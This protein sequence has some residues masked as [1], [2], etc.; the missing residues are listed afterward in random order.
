MDARRIAVSVRHQQ[1]TD[2][3]FNFSNV[4]NFL[5]QLPKYKSL[6]VTLSSCFWTWETLQAIDQLSG[7]I[8]LRNIQITYLSN[9]AEVLSGIVPAYLNKQ[10][11]FQEILKYLKNSG[12]NYYRINYIMIKNVNDSEKDFQIFAEKIKAVRGKVIVR[13]S[14]LNETEAANKNGLHSVEIGK[15]KMLKDI[16]TVVGIK[17]YLFYA[18][19]NDH[20]N[21][22]QLITE[23][24]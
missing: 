24:K 11:N 20:M 1:L 7:R 9:K 18:V 2:L 23:F 17:S 5:E 16:L 10:V 3:Y 13:I 15:M 19:K 14:K 21:C 12:K 4:K 8:S 6:H 22:G